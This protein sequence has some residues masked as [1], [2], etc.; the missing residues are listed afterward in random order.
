MPAFA[1]AAAER[2][3]KGWADPAGGSIRGQTVISRELT[4]SAEMV[5][6]IARLAAGKDFNAHHHAQAEI[7]FG[8]EGTGTVMIDGAPD[9]ISPGVSLFIPSHAE[10][11]V[12]P[13]RQPLRF[14]C[15]FATDSFDDV[16]YHWPDA[17]PPALAKQ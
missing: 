12:P 9:C 11:G 5:C 14:F 16:T 17:G 3:V 8:L 6:G 15:V 1:V 10:H 7:Y 2:P 13:V 4:D